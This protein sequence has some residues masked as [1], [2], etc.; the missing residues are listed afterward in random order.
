[1]VTCTLVGVGGT[2]VGVGAVVGL[3]VGV[4]VGVRVGVEVGVIVI[5]IRVPSTL[6]FCLSLEV[7]ASTIFRAIK[8]SRIIRQMMKR[9]RYRGKNTTLFI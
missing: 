4:K 9:G 8:I 7:L 3:G 1:M 2:R 5:P 6:S